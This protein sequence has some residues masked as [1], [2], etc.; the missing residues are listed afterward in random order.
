VATFAP[1]S[2]GEG[3]VLVQVPGY[4]RRHLGWRDASAEVTVKLEPEAVVAGELIDASTDKA[5]EAAHISLSSHKGGQVSA[6]VQPGD[7]GRFRIGELSGGSYVLAIS[8]ATGASLHQ[9]QLTLAPGQKASLSLRLPASGVASDGALEGPAAPT[10]GAALTQLKVGEPAPEFTS[11]TLADAPLSLKD[12]RG[13]Y[14]LL[15]FW[16]TWCGPCVEEIPHLLAAHESFGKD[17]RFA[18]ISLSLD[19]SKDDVAK[20]LKD[21]EQPWTHVFLGDWSEDPVTKK[22]GIEQIPSILLLDPEGKIVARDLRGKGI[23]DTVGNL[24]RR[25]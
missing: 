16:A 25:D 21:R 7:A 20:F 9:E 6:S 22:Y 10:P 15:D 1:L 5:L 19:A 24:L 12:Y 2:F 11:R 23:Q 14:V 3:T 4:A 17:P 18:M 8:T 13:K